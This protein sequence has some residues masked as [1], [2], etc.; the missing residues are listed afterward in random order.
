MVQETP[1]T[2]QTQCVHYGIAPHWVVTV[3]VPPILRL[4][5]RPSHRLQSSGH[6]RSDSQTRERQWLRASPMMT[7]MTFSEEVLKKNQ[8]DIREPPVFLM[9]MHV[10][11]CIALGGSIY[12]SWKWMFLAALISGLITCG[13][14]T[15]RNHPHDKVMVLHQGILWYAKSTVSSG[16]AEQCFPELACSQRSTREQVIEPRKGNL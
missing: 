4:L 9:N 14:N 5:M 2:C 6:Q 8:L 10:F 16:N 7:L 11:S 13:Q 3:T 15:V 12:S 1:D